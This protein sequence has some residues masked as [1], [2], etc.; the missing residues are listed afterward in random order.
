[1]VTKGRGLIIERR[2][3]VALVGCGRIAQKH[4]EAIASYREAVRGFELL[5]E[6]EATTTRPSG[7]GGH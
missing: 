4:I 5:H 2:I 1:M 6:G 3:R 7:F